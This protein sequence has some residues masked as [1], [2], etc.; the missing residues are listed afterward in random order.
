MAL[1]ILRACYVSR[2]HQDWNGSPRL[3][4]TK[5]TSLPILVQPTDVTRKQYTKCRL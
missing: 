3:H 1:G 2:L 4:H 5:E